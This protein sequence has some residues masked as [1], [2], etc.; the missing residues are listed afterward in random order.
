MT[1]RIKVKH[2]IYTLILVFA[3]LP[4]FSHYIQPKIEMNSIEANIET[5]NITKAKKQ[6]DKLLHQ[7]ISAN[8][9]WELV[10]KYMLDGALAHRFDVYVGP[11][12]SSWTPVAE[13]NFFTEEETIPYLMEY[14]KVGPIDGYMR[15]AAEQL[16]AYF[17]REGDYERADQ[18]LADTVQRAQT[19][20]KDY[21]TNELSFKRIELAFDTR[22]LAKA[23][24][25]IQQL[26]E[27]IDGINQNLPTMVALLETEKLLYMGEFDKALEK[28]TTDIEALKKLW[29]EE[30]QKYRDLEAKEGQQPIE[31]FGFEQSRFAREL[32]AIRNQLER[33]QKLGYDSLTTV[34]GSIMRSDGTPMA[35]VGVFL[36][37][38]SYV[39][40]SV[41]D[42][43]RFQTVTDEDG[44][45]RFNGVIPGSYQIHL[46]LRFE[47][48]DG[49]AW[50]IPLDDWIDVE[51]G[52]T[53]TYNI[54]FNPL[55]TI[56]SPVNHQEIRADEIKFKWEKVEQ[57]DYYNLNLCLEFDG[58]VTC[59]PI[60]SN[61]KE[62][63]MTILLEELYDKQSGVS[64]SG[65][66]SAL[67][68]V[69]PESLLAFANPEGEFSWYVEAF[70]RDG[71]MITKSNGYR[72]NKQ[73]MGKI[74]VFY[75][76]E[77]T[78][79]D[80]D[81]LLLD[82]KIVEALEF[83]KQAVAADPNDIHSLR[84]VARLI[85]FEDE[86][87][88]GDYR[89]QFSEDALPY[90]IALAEKRP[91]ENSVS[92][93][94]FYYYERRNWDQYERWF[95]EYER[96][97]EDDISSYVKSIHATARMRQGDLKKAQQLL[98]EVLENDPSRRFVG[99]LIAIELYLNSTIGN[100][101]RV[102]EQ[103]PQRDYD[104]PDWVSIVKNLSDVQKLDINE[105]LELYFF[106]DEQEMTQQL[107][108][109]KVSPPIET[110]IHALL[111]VR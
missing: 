74:P 84:M 24:A 12:M 4:V 21:I 59:S 29:D 102:A 41:S 19:A 70:D 66:G 28:V 40:M 57:A 67:E 82:H 87:E 62:N 44:F 86:G 42:D 39:N 5:G 20:K 96:I 13:R 48:V 25:L 7:K 49:W 33:A 110:L 6:I 78:L 8:E 93:L 22:N 80:A 64:F 107:E 18:I 16:A 104:S 91:T 36:R 43:E 63:E 31:E 27:E 45:Y 71:N 54:D 11:S 69:Q 30:N 38:E 105:A 73:S 72:L 92:T 94:V 55:I 68:T 14:I 15:S 89:S 97:I 85:G 51:D 53:I 75:L 60:K 100:A 3:L 1:V 32:F 81:R 2:L 58:G 9:R 108:K 17:Q 109:Q 88:N 23:E 83:Y 10:Q 47:Q 76:K 34:E 103:Y 56:D 61:V 98:Y 26:A 99:N 90:L 77:R 50:S 101:L 65:D 79:T 95:H 106:A 35:N 52:E 111:T 37:E 46:G